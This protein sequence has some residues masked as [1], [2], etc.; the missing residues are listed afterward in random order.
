ME[1]E[2]GLNR[3]IAGHVLLDD[4]LLPARVFLDLKRNGGNG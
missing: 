2:Y 3:I 4:R 1:A